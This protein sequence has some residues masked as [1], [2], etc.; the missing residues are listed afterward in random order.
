MLAGYLLSVMAMRRGD[1]AFIAPFRYT[2]LLWA[3]VLGFVLFDE[4][5]APATLIGSAIVVATGMF[6]F[7]RERRQARPGP[8]PLRMR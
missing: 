6:T 4:W 1:L 2:A 7:Y 8:V 5:P 3:L